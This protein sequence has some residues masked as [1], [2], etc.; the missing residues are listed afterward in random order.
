MK[1]CAHLLLIEAQLVGMAPSSGKAAS[2][3][4]ASERNK[5]RNTRKVR[6]RSKSTL[7]AIKR[8]HQRLTA[9][10]DLHSAQKDQL[11][12]KKR[13]VENAKRAA[14]ALTK[15]VNSVRKYVLDE[16]D[17]KRLDVAQ[18]KLAKELDGL[19]AH[20]RQLYDDSAQ[21]DSNFDGLLK[22][23][24]KV[25]VQQTR[26]MEGVVEEITNNGGNLELSSAR[27]QRGTGKGLV[28][29]QAELL[30][31]MADASRGRGGRG[32]RGRGGRGSARAA[33]R[34]RSAM[35]RTPSAGAS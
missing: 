24:E 2:K 19:D 25:E 3:S 30:K 20:I 21:G 34:A 15:I 9:S 23:L 31:V 14:I 33:A 7:G 28:R 35:A 22:Q 12:P 11:A 4:A 18:A 26:F 13:S 6:M 27:T 1:R 29:T 16:K 32:K 10:R 17:L 8:Q 5:Q